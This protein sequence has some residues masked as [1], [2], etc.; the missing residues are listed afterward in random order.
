MYGFTFA[1]Y[2][3]ARGYPVVSVLAAH[4]KHWK[5]LTHQQAL[6]TDAKDALV[7]TDLLAHGK[8]VGF[9]FLAEPYA[10]L[11]YLVSAREHLTTLRNGA[12]TRLAAVLDVV[13]PE[14]AQLFPQLQKPTALAILRAFPGPTALLRAP[15][16][17][18]LRVLVSA[19]QNHLGE[20]RYQELVE[21][22]RQ[23]VA[24]PTAQGV[25]KD[26]IPLLA[27]RLSLYDAQLAALKAR[28]I[29]VMREL[30]AAQALLTIPHVA[31]VTAA[32]FLG[33]VGDPSAYA[34][35]AQILKLAGLSLVERSSGRTR[36]E[37]R[38]SKRGRPVLR[39]HAFM[40]ALRSVRRDGLYRADFERLLAHNGGRK[41]AALTAISR[42]AL[43]LMFAIA[44]DARPFVGTGEWRSGSHESPAGESRAIGAAATKPAAD[45]LRLSRC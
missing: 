16:R 21:A 45:A 27:D 15:K 2:L 38:L 42:K 36:G 25:L 43:R 28:M 13:F 20:T 8:F 24:L 12:L 41:L 9:A 30:P 29:E 33:C 22:A 5:E 44:H 1:H 17:R 19:S 11:R 32:T 14:Y 40:F 34:S 35:S 6:K 18:V 39:R 37:R 10:A 4:T 23:S 31:P 7:I 26:E 3:H